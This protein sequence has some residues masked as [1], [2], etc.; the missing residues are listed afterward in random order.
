MLDKTLSAHSAKCLRDST[1][2]LTQ[3]R[4]AL[5]LAYLEGKKDTMESIVKAHPNSDIAKVLQGMIP[6]VDKEINDVII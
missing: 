3:Y 1:P 6:D 2:P 4:E 5:A